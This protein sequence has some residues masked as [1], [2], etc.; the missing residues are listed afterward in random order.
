MRVTQSTRWPG[1]F[2]VIVFLGLFLYLAWVGVAPEILG[3]AFG[4]ASIVS[5]VFLLCRTL[6]DDALAGQSQA[7]RFAI[8]LRSA[9]F[10]LLGAMGLGL[11]SHYRFLWILS[12]LGNVCFLAQYQVEMGKLNWLIRL[13]PREGDPRSR[14]TPAL[15]YVAAES[16]DARSTLNAIR[17]EQ[18]TQQPKSA[19]QQ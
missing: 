19:A 5:G 18:R 4:V 2:A 15:V 1:P 11:G 3:P 12:L 7:A 8:V 14:S 13:L 9:G 10:F 6:L 17:R 16:A